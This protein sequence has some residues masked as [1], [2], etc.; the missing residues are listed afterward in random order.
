MLALDSGMCC[1]RQ[2]NLVQTGYYAVCKSGLFR[3]LPWYNE[4]HVGSPSERILCQETPDLWLGGW[5]LNE[6]ETSWDRQTK[7]VEEV[8]AGDLG[9]EYIFFHGHDRLEII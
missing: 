2:L 3:N 5:F 7:E 9:C 1:G 6:T 8:L 4:S